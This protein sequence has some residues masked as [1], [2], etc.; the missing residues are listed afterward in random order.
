M[1]KDARIK[2]LQEEIDELH[3]KLKLFE[4]YIN[5]YENLDRKGEL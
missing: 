3:K 4:D 5:F 2:S 1:E